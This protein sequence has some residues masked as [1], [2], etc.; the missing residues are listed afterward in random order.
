MQFTLSSDSRGLL[1]CVLSDSG[2]EVTVSTSGQSASTDLL[3]AVE[4]AALTGFGECY[5]RQEVDEFRWLFRRENETVRVALLRGCGTLTG[6]EH[7]FWGQCDF[8][9][10]ASRLRNEV[11]REID[12]RRGFGALP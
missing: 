10:F 1:T 6:W 12:E 8:D 7:V 11:R 9:P 4:S 3:E 5:W 2:S